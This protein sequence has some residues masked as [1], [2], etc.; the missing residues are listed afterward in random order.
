[1]QTCNHDKPEEWPHDGRSGAPVQLTID[2]GL[3]A[4]AAR[5]MGNESGAVVVLDCMTGDMLAMASMPAYDPNSFSDGIGRSEWSMLSG[6]ERRPLNN[7]V[8]GARVL[9]SEAAVEHRVVGKHDWSKVPGLLH[10]KLPDA[11]LDPVVTVVALELDG[12]ASLFKEHVKPIE[13][14]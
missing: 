12:P 1:M 10:I 6:D 11:A 2:A 3:Q 9:G 7:K 5:R 8:L 13:S 4:Y 14:N